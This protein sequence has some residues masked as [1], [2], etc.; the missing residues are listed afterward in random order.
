MSSL[1]SDRPMS[2]YERALT[3][4]V[5]VMLDAMID[6]GAPKKQ[7]AQSLKTLKDSAQLDGHHTEAALIEMMMRNAGLR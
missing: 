1:Y 3:G 5:R 7:L 6:M 4:I 2:D